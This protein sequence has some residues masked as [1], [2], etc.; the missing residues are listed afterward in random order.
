MNEK[1]GGITAFSR[2]RLVPFIVKR[3]FELL[4]G[5]VIVYFLW[6][7]LIRHPHGSA[8]TTQPQ[9]FNGQPVQNQQA[10]GVPLYEPDAANADPKWGSSAGLKSSQLQDFARTVDKLT[11]QAKRYDDLF[12]LRRQKVQ[13][14]LSPKV[15][16][17]LWPA[18]NGSGFKDQHLPADWFELVKNDDQK[19]LNV[20]D[21]EEALHNETWMRI[22]SRLQAIQSRLLGGQVLTGDVLFCKA[23]QSYLDQN[24]GSL[25]KTVNDMDKI[26]IRMRREF[27]SPDTACNDFSTTGVAPSDGIDSHSSVVA[28]FKFLMLGMNLADLRI[29]Y[30]VVYGD[31]KNPVTKVNFDDSDYMLSIG[32]Y[33]LTSASGYFL[34]GRLYLIRLTFDRNQ[35]EIFKA[36]DNWSFGTTWEDRN[37]KRGEQYLTARARS[38]E[39]QRAAILA[40][41]GGKWDEIDICDYDAWTQAMAFY[42]P[43]NETVREK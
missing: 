18:L 17:L 14:L 8:E 42:N 25:Q 19:S 5:A 12:A 35:D 41:P 34:N 37:W 27:P 7:H 40:P 39:S 24:L 32:G 22:Q 1:L 29:K 15:K 38:Q 21:A 3:K 23:L 28:G 43:P 20:A 10:E 26:F 11:I 16:G 4:V 33:P 36:F 31:Q 30:A 13:T 9:S 2:Q 6:P